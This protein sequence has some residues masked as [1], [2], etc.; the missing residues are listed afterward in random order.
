MSAPAPR[1]HDCHFGSADRDIIVGYRDDHPSLVSIY[2]RA[3][4]ADYQALL[5][6]GSIIGPFTTEVA[7]LIRTNR[8]CSWPNH[9]GV[10]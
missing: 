3:D 7:E 10:H 2:V 9:L 8:K 1:F 4:D 5:R 6:Q